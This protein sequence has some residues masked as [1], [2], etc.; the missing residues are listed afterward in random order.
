VD[1]VEIEIEMT[2]K[3][4]Q[5]GVEKKKKNCKPSPSTDR[6]EIVSVQS[7]NR[8]FSVVGSRSK[9][10]NANLFQ[11]V[12]APLKGQFRTPTKDEK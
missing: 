3:G 6:G 8:F 9:Q 4:G 2:K 11:G 12:H 5:I 1:Y 10:K 7:K